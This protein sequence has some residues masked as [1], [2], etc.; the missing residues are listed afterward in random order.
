MKMYNFERK[1]ESEIYFKILN[2]ALMTES[3]MVFIEFAFTALTTQFKELISPFIIKQ[4]Q[5]KKW[6]GSILH[7]E[8]KIIMYVLDINPQLIKQIGLLI[9]SLWGWSYPNYPEDLSFLRKDGTPWFISTTHEDDAYMILEE[10]EIEKVINYFGNDLL[11]FDKE[12]EGN[13]NYLN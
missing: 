10:G 13:E 7:A 3:K 6:P 12:V 11:E 1:V 8:G 4:E 9:P 2:Y 5:V